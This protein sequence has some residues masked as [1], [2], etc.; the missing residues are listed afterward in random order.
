MTTAQTFLLAQHGILSTDSQEVISR[1]VSQYLCP[2]RMRLMGGPSLSS[3]MYGLMLDSLSIIELQYGAEVEIDPGEMSDSY[4]FRLTLD[5]HGDITYRDKVIPMNKG[6]IT[7]SSPGEHGL[8]HTLE[9]CHNVIVRVER[10]ALEQRLARAL[11]QRLGGPIV[12]DH[13][14][15]P[16]H[17][18]TK[19]LQRT[20]E[21]LVQVARHFNQA[22]S[23]RSQMQLT[24]AFFLKSLL[25][26]FSHNFSPLLSGRESALPH[27][28]KAAK[29]HIDRHFT[30][31]ITMSELAAVANVSVRSLQYG[32]KQFLHTSPKEYVSRERM[33]AI[34]HALSQAGPQARV[35]D[36]VMAH[37]VNSLGHFATQYKAVYGQ[38]P[39][40]TMKGK[41]ARST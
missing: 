23:L 1:Q 33:K 27:Y 7:V 4:L 6:G 22:T 34:H 10:E 15:P 29:E 37:G 8:I 18:G 9:D 5:G 3:R 11:D 40:D 19:Y 12:F 14:F 31:P 36:I 20:I 2:H 32:F 24:E 25:H 21:Y 13:Y 41:S 16:E 26:L 30:Q 38:T 28:V 39:L 17:P 35:T